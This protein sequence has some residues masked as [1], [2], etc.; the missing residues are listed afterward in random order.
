MRRAFPATAAV[1]DFPPDCQPGFVGDT[2]TAQSK[3]NYLG[4]FRKAVDS[5]EPTEENLAARQHFTKIYNTA[6]VKHMIHDRLA[7]VPEGSS[8]RPGPCIWITR[9]IYSTS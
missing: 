3:L 2:Q 6:K 4:R 5:A 9:H 8:S 1:P 7:T